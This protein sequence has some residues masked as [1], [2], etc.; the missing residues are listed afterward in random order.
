MSAHR[1]SGQSPLDSRS[2]LIA[3]LERHGVTGTAQLLGCS[4]STVRKRAR[5]LGIPPVKPGPR[6]N[7]PHLALVA[8][9][10]TIDA[11]RERVSIDRRRRN[12]APGLLATRVRAV[13]EAQ[14]AGE[15]LAHEDALLDLASVALLH[16]E[17]LRQLRGLA[18]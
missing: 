15:G 7:H 12:I 14:L 6:R 4:P 2:D 3:L 11:I 16:R 18:A 17:H 13:H 9:D 1:A 8:P 5:D 10:P